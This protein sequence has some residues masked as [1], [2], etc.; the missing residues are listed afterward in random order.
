M[1]KLGLSFIVLFSQALFAA[2]EDKVLSQMVSLLDSGKG[3]FYSLGAIETQM[4]LSAKS[5][6]QGKT[7]KISYVKFGKAK[8]SKGSLVIV[9]G[10][11]EAGLKYIEV[12]SD[13]I[14]KGYSPVYALDHR[15]Q[16]F[17]PTVTAKK[18][19]DTQIGHIENFDH[20]VKDFSQFVRFVV[21]KDKNVDQKN[22]FLL[23]NSMGGAIALRYFQQNPVNPFKKSALSAS[24]FKIITN[25]EL[26]LVKTTAVCAVGKIGKLDCYGYTPGESALAW[27][28]QEI[29]PDGRA[30]SV[31]AFYGDDPTNPRNLTSSKDRFRINDYLWNKWPQAIVA[32]PTIKWTEQSLLA[33]KVLRERNELLKVQ[34]DI[35]ILIASRDFRADG[36]AQE[37]VCK[38]LKNC[39]KKTYDSY[40]EILMETDSIRNEAIKDILNYFGK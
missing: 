14:S 26:A 39:R 19:P 10:R 40:H 6:E 31:R 33:G 18:L 23:S 7:I 37:R 4:G 22:L 38:T 25:D 30:I 13:F 1:F 12:A 32:G 5:I 28:G 35:F 17:S 24:M 2:H 29:L 8:G 15:G 9:P 20:Y 21:L 11:T 27:A 34:N 3:S 36:P 16:G